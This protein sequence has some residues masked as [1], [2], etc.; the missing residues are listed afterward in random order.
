MDRTRG[1]A[2]GVLPRR[3][4][5]GAQRY[6]GERPGREPQNLLKDG[7]QA[8]EKDVTDVFTASDNLSLSVSSLKHT[9]VPDFTSTCSP[10]PPPVGRSL[11]ICGTLK[12]TERSY[13]ISRWKDKVA[14]D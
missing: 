3:R 13:Q 2:A 9:P 11:P 5:T 8:D 10:P 7:D 4:G 12:K 1:A 14:V 6:R